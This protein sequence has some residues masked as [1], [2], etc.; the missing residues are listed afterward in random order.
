VPAKVMRTYDPASGWQPP[1]RD[2]LIE[3]PPDWPTAARSK[4]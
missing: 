1:L 2:L 3:P 4:G